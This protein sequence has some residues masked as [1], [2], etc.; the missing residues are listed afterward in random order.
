MSVESETVAIIDDD[1]MVRHALKILLSAYGYVVE[2]YDSGEAF[3]QRAAACSAICLLV[4]VQLG[5]YSGFELARQLAE[6]GFDFPVIFMTA[7][8][9][10]E[11]A[12]RA[13]EVGGI[14]CL[15]KPFAA[16]LLTDLLMRS[17]RGPQR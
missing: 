15:Q 17:K 6:A 2:L 8:A 4:D 13:T 12:L 11:V 5:S 1:P 16:K 7:N 3:L 14:A 9:D 10:E